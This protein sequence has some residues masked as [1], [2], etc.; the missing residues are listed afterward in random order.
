VIWQAAVSVGLFSLYYAL[1]AL[2]LASF[3]DRRIVG[4]IAFLGVVLV[5]SA[6]AGVMIGT[7][8]D[9]KTPF[10]LLSVV[11]PPRALRD[12]VFLGHVHWSEPLS[13]VGGAAVMALVIYAAIVTLCTSVLLW[14]YR[15]VQL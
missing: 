2:A 7:A 10:A 12:V 4:A 13:G 15:E 14:R 1:I 6:T 11:T 8:P 3:T 5:S 9:N